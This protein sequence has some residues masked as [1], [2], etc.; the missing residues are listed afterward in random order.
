LFLGSDIAGRL[1]RRLLRPIPELRKRIEEFKKFRFDPVNGVI[2]LHIRGLEGNA[3][4]KEREEVF[5]R[6]AAHLSRNEKTKCTNSSHE[7]AHIF[8]L[9]SHFK[10]ISFSFCCVVGFLATDRISSRQR[11]LEKIGDR[12]LFVNSTYDRGSRNGSSF[13]VDVLSQEY[14]QFIDKVILRYSRRPGRNVAFRRN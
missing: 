3:I 5:W 6:C 10:P 13:C 8:V 7:T 2:G 11:L 9:F 12:L 14:K 4:S 1:I